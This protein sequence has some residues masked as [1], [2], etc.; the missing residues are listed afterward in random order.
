MNRL[1][2]LLMLMVG[3]VMGVTVRANNL[4]NAVD[5]MLK[6]SIPVIHTAELDTQLAEN[7]ELVLLDA[8]EKAEYELSHLP[9][10]Q[11]IGY[12]EFS[13]KSVADANKDKTIVVYCSIGVRSERI[14]EKLK[15]NGFKTVLNLYGGIFAWANE[16]RILL[17]KN[18]LPTQSVHGYNKKWAQ[19]L[20][21]HV[22]RPQAQ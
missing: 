16:G 5:D 20:E 21:P 11:W 10:A 9:N 3:S 2:C 7:D 17:D 8:R 19:L 22:H 12:D 14:A 4:N 18:Q 15:L 1:F 6:G 13:L